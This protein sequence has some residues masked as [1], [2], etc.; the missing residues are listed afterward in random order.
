LNNLVGH[1]EYQSKRDELRKK[2]EILRSE[3]GENLPLNGK[4]PD[5]IRLPTPT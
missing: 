3:L 1:S 5:P 4:L 2:L